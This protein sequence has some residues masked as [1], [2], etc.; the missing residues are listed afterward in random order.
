M[1]ERLIIKNFGPIKSVDLKLGKMTIL[2]GEQATGKSTIAKVLAICRYFSYV[3]NYSILINPLND[4]SHNEQFFQG[5]KNWGIDTYLKENSEISFESSLYKFEFRNTLITEHESVSEVDTYLK[6]YFQPQT[7]LTAKS[8]KFRELLNQLNQLRIDESEIKNNI[9]DNFWLHS[10]TPNENFY[11][12]NVKKVMDNP[13]Y[14]PTE[15]VIQS[16]SLGKDLLVSDALQDELS[17]LNKIVRGF[18]IE[19]TIE[20]LS[21]TYKNQNGLGFIKKYEDEIYHTLHN[22]ASGYQSTIPIVLAIKFYNKFDK[23]ERT[24]IVE[25]PEQNLFPKTQ[26]K[27]IEFIVDSIN[28]GGNKF[29]LPTHSP[30]ILTSLENLVFAYKLANLQDGKYKAEV[31]E[32]VEEKYWLNPSDVSVYYLNE[33]TAID[34]FD[35]KEVLINKDYIDSVSEVINQDFEKLLNIELKLENDTAE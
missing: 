21:L 27:I 35:E 6:E 32:I 17:K 8:E 14:I 18:S 22:G 3:T 5:L 28:N 10:W 26:K 29:I 9:K 12:L 30:Y 19:M 33:D 15:R 31:N 24:F 34:I 7:R 13:M 23:R 20:P 11:R 2:I 1:K 4:F 16:T 25:E